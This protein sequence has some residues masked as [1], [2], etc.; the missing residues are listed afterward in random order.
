MA[1]ALVW[2]TS[3]V[4]DT[5]ERLLSVRDWATPVAAWVGLLV[6]FMLFMTGGLHTGSQSQYEQLS[7]QV[8]T[9]T[10]TIKDLGS[11]IGDMPSA[12]DYA[13]QIADMARF[14]TQIEAMDVRLQ[15]EQLKLERD[16]T[17]L[18]QLLSGIDAK[19]RQPGH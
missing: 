19:V 4:D 10:G 11:K 6:G 3:V 15:E 7:A 16:D 12:R 18:N 2:S 14:R 5:K 9:L 13:N 17:L 8:E 1:H